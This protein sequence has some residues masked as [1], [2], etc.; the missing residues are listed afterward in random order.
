MLGVE[1]GQEGWAE[2]HCDLSFIFCRLE[3]D[4][5]FLW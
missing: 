2:R 4:L 5:N 3:T 1:P